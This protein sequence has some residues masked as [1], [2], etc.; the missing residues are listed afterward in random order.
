LL[1]GQ[2]Q[3][4]NLNVRWLHGAIARNLRATYE[5]LLVPVKTTF[6]GYEHMVFDDPSK[7]FFTESQPC[8]EGKL[9]EEG[10]A[11]I[12]FVL[13]T[14]DDPPG[15]LN[16]IFRGKVFEESGDF[17]IDKTIIPYVPYKSFVGL[18]IPE[19]DK[20]GMLVTDEDHSVG[21]ATLNSKGEPITMES[22]EVKLYKL[23]WRWW[24]DNTWESS[25]NYTSQYSSELIKTDR[26][27]TRDGKGTYKLRVDYPAWGRYFLTMTDNISGHSAG[28]VFYIDWPGWAGK[29]KG[30]DLGGATRL[31]FSVESETVTVGNK[32]RL[33]IPSSEGGRILVSLETG[34]KLLE[35]FWVK[36]QAENTNIE[37]EATASMAPNIYAN[38]TMIQPHAQ[39]SNDLP[40]RMYGIQCIEV[41]DPETILKPEINMPDE[42]SPGETFQVKI[43][44]K[45]GKPMAYTLAIVEDGLLDLTKFKTP[46]PHKRFYAREALGV[47]TWDVFDD[48]MGS[49]G[50]QIEQM[51]A[52]GGDDEVMGPDEK[53]AN[54]FKP[55]VIFKG[56]YYLEPG[57]KA[58]HEITMPQYIGSVRTMVVSGYTGAYGNADKTIPVKQPLMIL[59]TLPRVAGPMEEFKLPVNIFTMD[60]NIKNVNVEVETSGK[61]QLKGENKKHL[62]FRES[63][64]QVIYFNVAAT[65]ELG[66]GK[67]K[68]K[69][70]SGDMIAEYD[71]ELNVRASNPEI[72]QVSET[73]LEG[74]SEWRMGY[75]PLGMLGTNDG[76][77]EVS[78]LP[79]LN[80]EQRLKYLIKYPHGCIEQTTSAVFAQLYLDELVDLSDEQS[81]SIQKNINAAIERFRSFQLPSGSFSFWPGR[82]EPTYWGT[83][84]AGHFMIEARNQGYLVPEDMIS[85]WISFQQEQA[86][87]WNKGTFNDYLTQSYRLYALS[88]AGNPALG[89]MN[90]MKESA[91][92]SNRGRWA[93]ASAY[94]AAGYEDAANEILAGASTA[95]DKYRELGR[96]YGSRQR[97]QG[98][99][100]ETLVRLNKQTDAFE[101]IRDI[102]E[103]MGNSNNW[104]S[105]Q[106]TAYC[107][108]G[109]AEFAKK[110]PPGNGIDVKV[111]IADNDF[112]VDTDKYINQ[113][114]LLEPDANAN[115]E[116]QNSGKTSLFVRVI[117][118][119]VPI[120]G[121]EEARESNIKMVINYRD[122]NGN[123]LNPADIEQ[124]TDF[125]AEV[126]VTNPG[127]RGDYEEVAITQIFPSGWEIINTRLDD[128]DLLMQED[129][130]EYKDI[131]DDRVMSYFDLKQHKAISIKVLLNAS[132]QGKYYL[133]AVFVEAMYD[134][135]IA[136]NTVGQWINVSANK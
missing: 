125:V 70:T 127:F 76:V 133:P 36:T 109:I 32:I 45:N 10:N 22:I 95:V 103:Y 130:P 14:E 35:T 33:N 74:G 89:A 54:R 13:K 38:I 72:Y 39:S 101:M 92:L 104:M 105:T 67:V 110:F 12:S 31:D 5:V 106:A 100:L 57:K 119:G 41:T 34:S 37:F 84:Y 85:S 27:S 134:N 87:E 66:V 52:V 107:L 44:E 124:G 94:A 90:R 25:S 42:L 81:A 46:D 97:D 30:G 116:I 112:R 131:R 122:M 9:D 51:M 136:A 79:P 73:V 99:I 17:S 20:R 2:K 77:V 60:D 135:S 64:D 11:R 68:V 114:T 108:I 83:N 26:I 126:E 102:A 128:V 96:T 18:Q 19:G 132:Y 61:L 6:K 111:S 71:I 16:A 4:G 75:E 47:K 117:R 69:A 62:T 40:I 59:A 98:M 80:L 15:M 93:L 123:T 55:V 118:T 115:I 121:V 8:Y 129:Q 65:S 56:P 3:H 113:V 63:G 21:I 23:R 78:S 58:E 86:N 49:Y 7:E 88:L 91:R 50:G 1:P 120:E 53:E 43:S 48:V 82:S 29:Q 28:K 24:W